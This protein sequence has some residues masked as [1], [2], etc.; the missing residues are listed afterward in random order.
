MKTLR[1]F[2]HWVDNEKPSLTDYA[3]RGLKNTSP[4]AREAL[5]L[6]ERLVSIHTGHAGQ[7][8][9]DDQVIGFRPAVRD[10]SFSLCNALGLMHEQV[11]KDCLKPAPR[12]WTEA[13]FKREYLC[14]WTPAPPR[15][16][17]RPL[18]GYR[19]QPSDFEPSKI[20]ERMQRLMNGHANEMQRGAAAWP[21][22]YGVDL[23]NEPGYAV[24]LATPCRGCKRAPCDGT[25]L[26]CRL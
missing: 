8:L 19:V 21:V 22:H 18:S 24:N 9:S 25:H 1:A 7:T 10:L 2:W 15:E 14:D 26:M 4:L 3:E 20:Q 6:A 16:L 5:M 11:E 17:D 23:G 13:L 12:T